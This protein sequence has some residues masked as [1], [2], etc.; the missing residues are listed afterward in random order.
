MLGYFKN[1]SKHQ[2][3]RRMCFRNS[4]LVML[5]VIILGIAGCGRSADEEEFYSK[6]KGIWVSVEQTKAGETVVFYEKIDEGSISSGFYIDTPSELNKVSIIEVIKKNSNGWY[7]LTIKIE[8]EELAKI[9][10]NKQEL[11]I[12]GD[13]LHYPKSKREFTRMS[14]E[15][16]QKAIEDIAKKII[17]DQSANS[18]AGIAAEFNRIAAGIWCDVDSAK[19]DMYDGVKSKYYYFVDG[20]YGY[21]YN[22]FYNDHK[23]ASIGEVR[24]DTD[25]SYSISSQNEYGHEL[26]ERLYFLQNAF[27]VMDDPEHVFVYSG[28]SPSNIGKN[29]CPFIRGH[30]ST[31]LAS[32]T[33][34]SEYG[35]ILDFFGLARKWTNTPHIPYSLYDVNGDGIPEMFL[36]IGTNP[37]DHRDIMLTIDL[38]TGKARYIAAL[39]KGHS[40][41]YV[42]SEPNSFLRRYRSD[43]GLTPIKYKIE[44]NRLVEEGVSSQAMADNGDWRPVKSYLTSDRSGLN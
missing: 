5:L 27:F 17:A 6:A 4:M 38:P 25:G 20:K 1:R 10:S 14:F 11:Y 18:G 13:T 19:C 40:D 30:E 37:G 41:I 39:W 23:L 43:S 8:D 33:W 24:K 9:V 7:E 44:G 32:Q 22:S 16:S 28:K 2:G 35:K 26:N 21:G 36:C 15:T 34:R 12:L 42:S 3:L 29:E 31:Q